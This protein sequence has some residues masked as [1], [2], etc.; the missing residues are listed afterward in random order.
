M[1]SHD[2]LQDKFRPVS[3]KIG[4]FQQPAQGSGPGHTVSAEHSRPVASSA[5]SNGSHTEGE[6][7]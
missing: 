5:A 6:G 3:S 4:I 2:R 1:F 7:Q